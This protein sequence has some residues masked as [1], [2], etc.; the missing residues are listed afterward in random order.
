MDKVRVLR[1]LEYTGDR[2]WV[3]ET[4]S[5]SIQGKVTTPRGTIKAVTIDSFPE[6]LD[7]AEEDKEAVERMRGPLL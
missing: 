6:I 1:I 7:Y 2:D 5:K 4:I 3:E